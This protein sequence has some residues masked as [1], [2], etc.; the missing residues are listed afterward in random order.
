[1]TNP[2]QERLQ[3]IVQYNPESGKIYNKK[4]G[5]EYSISEDNGAITIYDP[6]MKKRIK[7]RPDKLIWILLYG[8]PPDS[9]KRI[10]HRNLNQNDNRLV[11]LLL[12]PRRVYN[13]IS[14]ASRNLSGALK[15]L[16]HPEDQYSYVLTYKDSG[17]EHNEIIEDIVVAR[18]K[19]LK[20]QLKYAKLLS[21]YCIFD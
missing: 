16:P 9:D 20:L 10:L 19:L 1:M 13:Q 11:N 18:K 4:S 15:L 21:K 3:S 12:V 7:I 17:V 5:R 2:E 14:E 8:K 6:L